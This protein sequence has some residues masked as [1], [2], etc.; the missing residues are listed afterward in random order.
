MLKNHLIRASLC[1]MGMAC[2]LAVWATN[3]ALVVERALI[4]DPV[5]RAA[6]SQNQATQE[7][8]AQSIAPLLPQIIYQQTRSQNNTDSATITSQGRTPLVTNE[9]ESESRSL[10]VRQAL[11]RPR[12]VFNWAQGRERA[13]SGGVKFESARQQTIARTVEL[14]LALAVRQEQR[15]AAQIALEVASAKVQQAEKL[16]TVEEV[17]DVVLAG[18]KASLVKAKARLKEADMGLE[19]VR[20]DLM[21]IT[22]ESGTR[23]LREVDWRV[24]ANRLRPHLEASLLDK[25]GLPEMDSNPEVAAQ[26]SA[27][28]IA[29]LELRKSQSDHSPTLDLV[30]IVSD[31]TSAQD[32]VINRYTRTRSIGVQLTIPIFSGGATQSVVR[33][34]HALLDKARADLEVV[35]IRVENERARWRESVEHGLFALEAGQSEVDAAKLYLRLA[36]KGLVAGIHSQVDVVDARARLSRATADL[37]SAV[38]DALVAYVRYR[39]ALGALSLDDIRPLSVALSS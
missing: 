25:G 24:C 37:A 16:R 32:I 14:Y 8:R 39:V 6:A 31:G 26:R 19:A 18:T 21:A 30:A 10:S 11:I 2:P 12:A 22:G 28:E 27:V 20:R 38:A 34:Q 13:E 9:Y 36:E 35:H 29:R 23:V 4:F 17:S 33:E 1:L 5:L 7:Q 15:Y 3:L